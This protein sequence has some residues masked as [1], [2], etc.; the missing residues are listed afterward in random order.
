MRSGKAIAWLSFTLGIGVSVA[1]NIAHA[2][3][4]GWSWPEVGGSAFWPLALM[5]S[6]EILTRVNWVVGRRWVV[7][8]F[9]GLVMVALVA[10]VLSYRHLAGLMT[11]W[12]EDWLNAHLGPFA[13]DGL[14]LLAATA[15][16]SI[17]RTEAAPV[18]V[19]E[20]KPKRT[21]R[22]KQIR[23]VTQ[24]E[25]VIDLGR[26]DDLPEPEP[27]KLHVVNSVPESVSEE[28]AKQAF[29]QSGGRLSGDQIAR[30]AGISRSSGYRRASDWRQEIQ[31]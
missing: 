27:S 6:I 23:S 28:A 15:L 29:L 12:G 10:A 24:P 25:T 19:A 3:S 8:R 31:R 11:S 21:P 1:G 22:P 14:M 2:V 17:S 30:I 4:D 26:S 13:V 9:A 5:L 16:L 20:P 18:P 7:A